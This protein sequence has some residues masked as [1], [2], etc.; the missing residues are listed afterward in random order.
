MAAAADDTAPAGA[1]PRSQARRSIS[2]FVG[3]DPSS[4]QWSFSETPSA[5]AAAAALDSEEEGEPVA[6][7]LVDA[8]VAL[9]DLPSTASSAEPFHG[10]V[11]A[12]D[13]VFQGWR[14][15]ISL[16]R[17]TLVP[18]LAAYGYAAVDADTWG[19]V[20]Q[21]PVLEVQVLG[22]RAVDL[23]RMYLLQCSLELGG[24]GLLRWVAPRRL[25]DLREDLHDRVK[26]ALGDKV[27]EHFF[28]GAPFA[29]RGGPPGTTGRLRGWTAA[30]A[31]CINVGGASPCATAMAL[32]FLTDGR[33]QVLP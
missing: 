2:E 31:A 28:A 13:A 21:W 23:H 11:R 3:E 27:Y 16:S 15:P 20:E 26:L 19:E 29:R 30:L 18:Y 12:I 32:K 7:A 1:S 5:A 9:E 25:L 24:A 10:T 22:H 14:C 17:S 4:P 6:Q 8:G 33:R